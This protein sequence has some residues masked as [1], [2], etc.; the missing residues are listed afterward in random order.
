MD[1]IPQLILNSIIA[2]AIYSLI[3]LGIINAELKRSTAFC[4]TSKI[5]RYKTL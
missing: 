4:E 1:I 2:G 3:A 5:I